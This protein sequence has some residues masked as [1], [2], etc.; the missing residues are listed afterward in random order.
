MTRFLLLVLPKLPRV[1][2][3]LIDKGLAYVAQ[4]RVHFHEDRDNC[5]S[6]RDYCLANGRPALMLEAHDPL[7]GQRAYQENVYQDYLAARAELNKL[8]VWLRGCPWPAPSTAASPVDTVIYHLNR[9][10]AEERA[11][12]ATK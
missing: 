11:K 4:G 10:V 1:P 7:P 2:G 5:A 9:L 6:E 3:W 12:G 8:T